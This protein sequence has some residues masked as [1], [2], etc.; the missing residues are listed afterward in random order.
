MLAGDFSRNIHSQ[1]FIEK[2]KTGYDGIEEVPTILVPPCT[3]L[4]LAISTSGGA[5]TIALLMHYFYYIYINN[6][7]KIIYEDTAQGTK[8]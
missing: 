7:L 2:E 3:A 6:K 5:T 8:K 1:A 4:A